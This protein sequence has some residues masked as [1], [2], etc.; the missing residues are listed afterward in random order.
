[1]ILFERDNWQEI[2]ATIKK[3]KLRTT[4]TMFG[5]FWG[6]FM[7]VIMLGSGSG[8]RHGV[9]KEFEGEST[10][11]FFVWAQTTTKPYKGMKA[12]RNYNFKN[13]DTKAL[14]QIA[15]LET[16]SPESQL[17]DY[18]NANNVTRGLK[19]GSF[20]VLG[21]YPTVTKIENIKLKDGRFLNQND[22]KERRKVCVIGTRVNEMLFKTTE[23]AVGD[24]IKIN[25]VNFKVIGIILP[26]GSGQR[27][28]ETS[29]K[30]RIPFST[31]QHAFHTGDNLTWYSLLAKKGIPASIAEE[32]TI[33]ILKERHKIASED[34]QGVGHWNTEVQFNKM[35]GLFNGIEWLVWF[36]GAGTLIAGV[37]GVSN[38]MLI[39]V[40][41]RTKEIGL[42]RALGA[43]PISVILQIMIESLF[44]TSLSGII[45][46]LSGM[47]IINLINNVLPADEGGMFQ[48]P[49][50]DIYV[51]I[52]ALLILVISGAFAGLIPARKAVAISPVEAL[53]YD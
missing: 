22:I 13:A 38:I 42:K 43:T 17:G 37:I 7:L 50:V 24:Y 36:V 10:N 35:N 46:L 53:R 30:I 16:I 39:V 5:V 48:N 26:Q 32:K 47:G 21:E 40:K 44:L 4:L 51:V 19:I 12:G 52:G 6:I 33:A 15:E 49:T 14:E 45:G 25:G 3:N 18:G 31:F 20:Q 29:Q 8:L 23:K 28:I 2:F 41:E 11:S 27:Y 1:M 9:L 34:N